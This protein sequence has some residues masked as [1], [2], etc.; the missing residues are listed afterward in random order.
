MVPPLGLKFCIP[1]RWTGMPYGSGRVVIPRP[2][3]LPTIFAAKYKP[4]KTV[5]EEQEKEEEEEKVEQKE[6][7]GK[8]ESEEQ[9]EKMCDGKKN[10][11]IKKE[12][13][14]I[15]KSQLAK[16]ENKKQENE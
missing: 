12:K 14:K 1:L 3:V 16:L 11:V 15:R 4:I 10:M 8:H 13:G 7:K 5:R 2:E 9:N 6:K